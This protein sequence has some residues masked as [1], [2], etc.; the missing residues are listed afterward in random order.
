MVQRGVYTCDDAKK[1]GFGIEVR[2]SGCV[3]CTSRCCVSWRMVH[4][5]VGTMPIPHLIC[6][7][8]RSAGMPPS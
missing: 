3:T 8:F 1:L 5:C 6:L 2:V 4:K 7:Q